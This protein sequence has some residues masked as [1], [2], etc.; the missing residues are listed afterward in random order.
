M[1]DYTLLFISNSIFF[2]F[3]FI[4]IIIIII[5]IIFF[6]FGEGGVIFGWLKKLRFQG[7][8]LLMGCLAIS[9]FLILRNLSW[10]LVVYS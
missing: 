2:Y 1:F 4:I 9:K 3:L 6:F 10:T 5:I 8:K 7:Y